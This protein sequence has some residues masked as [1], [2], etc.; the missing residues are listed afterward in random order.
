MVPSSRKRRVRSKPLNAKPVIA[1][2]ERHR[3]RVK[4]SEQGV[5]DGTRRVKLWVMEEQGSGGLR[6][7]QRQSAQT[8][9]S[10]EGETRA[11]VRHKDCN[12]KVTS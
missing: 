8:G 12:K 1:K 4:R 9:G 10:D 7:K 2:S 3:R 5:G 11:T 6:S